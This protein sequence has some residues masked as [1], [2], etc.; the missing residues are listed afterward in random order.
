MAYL[1]AFVDAPRPISHMAQEFTFRDMT[2]FNDQRASIEYRILTM[3]GDEDKR[4]GMGKAQ[5]VQGPCRL[6]ALIY[7]NMVFREL[8]P[9][10]AIHTTLTS[11]LR[12]ELMQM[13]LVSCSGNLGAVLL[14]IL[15]VGGAVAVEEPIRS[16]FVSTLTLVC[17]QLELRSWHDTK[18]SL[19]RYLW[20]ERIWE[21]R[22][23]KL[24]FDVLD[25]QRDQLPY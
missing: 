20:S 21:Q 17:S 13:N 8:Q 23:K 9:R 18:G 10:A 22:C 12:A 6:A 7:I 15:F 24:W 16:W 5:N 25:E 11:Y 1:T 2:Y 19:R 4:Q 3:A 14:W